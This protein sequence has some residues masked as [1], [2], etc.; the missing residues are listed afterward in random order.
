MGSFAVAG[1]TFDVF[2]MV[3]FGLIGFM[4]RRLDF[5]IPPFVIGLV[6]GELAEVNLRRSIMIGGPMIFFT[7]PLST[8]IILVSAVILLMPFIKKIKAVKKA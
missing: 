6:L 7:R 2:V 8:A 4:L 1:T 3:T 5:P